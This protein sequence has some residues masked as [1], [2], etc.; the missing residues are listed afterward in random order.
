MTYTTKMWNRT[1]YGFE[2]QVKE[3]GGTFSPSLV[4]RSRPSNVALTSVIEKTVA[5]LPPSVGLEAGRIASEYGA[6]YADVEDVQIR[7]HDGRSYDKLSSLM[8]E[9]ASDV[10]EMHV[11]QIAVTVKTVQPGS[12]SE[13]VSRTSGAVPFTIAR[14]RSSNPVL[15][16]NDQYDRNDYPGISAQSIKSAL[17]GDAAVVRFKEAS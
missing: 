10:Q 8:A 9:Q 5:F 17:N 16:W 6:A 13:K 11:A 4:A 2:L 1:P 7:T 15:V 12:M 14:E 3:L